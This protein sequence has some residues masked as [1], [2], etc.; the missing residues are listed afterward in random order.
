MCSIR[1]L[2]QDHVKKNKNI[3]CILIL[4]ATIMMNLILALIMISGVLL[5]AE[6]NTIAYFPPPL[7]QILDGILPE[8][9]TCTEG[10]SLVIKSTNGLPSCVKHTSIEKLIQRGWG[11]AYFEPRDIA[12]KAQSIWD[13]SLQQQE[14]EFEGEYIEGPTED[15]YEIIKYEV[16]GNLIEKTA[17]PTLPNNLIHLQ[18]DKEKHHEIWNNF[19]SLIPKEHRNVSVFYLTTDGVGEIGGGVNRDLDDLT[20]WYLF[21]DINDSY[22]DGK[23]D[24]KSTIHTSI[25][26]FGHILTTSSNQMDIDSELLKLVV[27]DESDKITLDEIFVAK[28]EECFPRYLSVDGCTKSNSYINQF[29]QQFWIDMVSEWDDIQYVD[30]DDEYYEQSDRFYE[31]YQDRF[32]SAYASTN[33]DEDISESWTAFVLT[34]KP[35]KDSSGMSEQKILFFYDYPE[36]IELREDIRNNL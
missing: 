5:T 33:V 34:N 32:V 17:T 1:N 9:V 13:H 7:K 14:N 35:Q 36:L 18:E 15:G 19:T 20:K 11:T 22:P 12:Q 4:K 6:A 31:K 29:Y 10:L 24:E 25:H 23:F 8:N 30:D 2:A 26:E 28:A 3:S 21:Y 27:D 16:F